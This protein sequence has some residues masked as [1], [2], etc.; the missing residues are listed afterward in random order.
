[1][2]PPDPSRDTR[3]PAFPDATFDPAAVIDDVVARLAPV[4]HLHGA[5]LG[6]VWSKDLP[7]VVRGD[8]EQVRHTLA[9]ALEDAFRGPN[10]VRLTVVWREDGEL[11]VTLRVEAGGE[12]SD[13]A[14]STRPEDL[15]FPVSVDARAPR[16]PSRAALIADGSPAVQAAVAS[17]TTGRVTAVTNAA[18]LREALASRAFPLAFVDV[19]LLDPPT[20]SA[21]AA[22]RASG[23]VVVAMAR[24]AGGQAPRVEEFDLDGL[25][26]KPLRR[27]AT[28]TFLTARRG[29]AK[30][31]A[32]PAVRAPVDPSL[33][34]PAIL[35]DQVL[36]LPPLAAPAPPTL[37]DLAA[38]EDGLGRL[39]HDVGALAA[40]EL[41]DGWILDTTLRVAA[42]PYLAGLPTQP[43]RPSRLHRA[44]HTLKGNCPLFGL[45]RLNAL[46]TALAVRT[47][48]D[49]V[50]ADDPALGELW[51]HFVGIRPSLF[52]L[53]SRLRASVL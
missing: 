31:R 25:V 53:S 15:R 18:A 43:G 46:S 19:E 29:K 52:A 50:P 51:A 2:S 37:A 39:D 7:A 26:E 20:F 24:L 22:A 48:D 8:V 23:V 1:M 6:V 32:K 21:L 38:L 36:A 3:K 35:P 14:R 9:A 10:P 12:A 41:L 44:A 30:A 47:L 28:R 4:A 17:L 40:A 49:V 5:E 16:R 34:A 45:R 42:L 27:E 33:D 13:P 11:T